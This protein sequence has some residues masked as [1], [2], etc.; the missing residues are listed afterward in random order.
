MLKMGMLKMRFWSEFL[1]KG[2]DTCTCKQLTVAL[3]YFRLYYDSTKEC[4]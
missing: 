3:T 1:Y 4:E 2:L